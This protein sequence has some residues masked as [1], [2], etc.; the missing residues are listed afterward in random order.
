ML[1]SIGTH[2]CHAA[3]LTEA[4]VIQESACCCR[5]LIAV[6]YNDMPRLVVQVV[7]FPDKALFFHKHRNPYQMRVRIVPAPYQ[8]ISIH[9]KPSLQNVRICRKQQI[10]HQAI[11][12]C[13]GSLTIA[14]EVSVVHAVANFRKNA[15]IPP[16]TL[17][18]LRNVLG[19]IVV[20][21]SLNSAC[22]VR[23]HGIQRIDAIDIRHKI[24]GI[25]HA[26]VCIGPAGQK[27][28]EICL[29]LRRNGQ[30]VRRFMNYYLPTADKLMTSY[31]LMMETDSPG[32]NIA[33]AMKSVENSLEMIA[34]AFERQLD[35]L[36][37]DKSLDIETDIQVL[38]TMMAGDGLTGGSFTQ[39]AGGQGAVRPGN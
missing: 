2:N 6:I 5:R 16:G 29:V 25:G 32:E 17:V 9:K 12:G 11:T 35:N 37:K 28:N 10:H 27:S 1:P 7:Q 4:L 3:N 23:I 36:Y 20:H 24:S 18:V 13:A 14:F 38:E 33:H 15:V 39:Q 34:T 31:R 21:T 30:A 8:L 26:P 19:Q 22:A